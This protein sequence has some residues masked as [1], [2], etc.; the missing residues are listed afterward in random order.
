MSTRRLL[1]LLVLAGLAIGL[2]ACSLN[3]PQ[4]EAASPAPAG[5]GFPLP[6]TEADAPRVTAQ[7][8]KSAFERGEAVIVDVR[9]VASYVKKHIAGARSIPLDRIEADPA[10]VSLDPSKW[11]I[12]YCT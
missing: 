5:T 9:S 6:Q 8:A 3:L 12:T 11:I 7:D 10:G 1:P 2:L 4:T